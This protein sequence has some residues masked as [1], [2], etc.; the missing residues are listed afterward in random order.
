MAWFSHIST[1][2]CFDF[3]FGIKAE[4]VHC[5]LNRFELK[6]TILSNTCPTFPN[7]DH[8]TVNSPYRTINGLC[9]NIHPPGH[10]PWGLPKTQYQRAL[11]PNYA[12]GN[13]NITYYYFLAQTLKVDRYFINDF[14]II[15]WNRL[16]DA[17]TGQKW[18]RATAVR[19]WLYNFILLWP[20]KS[21]I[22]FESQTVPV[23]YLWLWFAILTPPAIRTLLG[24]CN[25]PNSSIM[26]NPNIVKSLD[27]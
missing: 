17:S 27:L 16:M 24:L 12:D 15:I 20:S 4:Q 9:N 2:G 13:D 3:R 19:I 1:I 14:V 5:A 6:D 18:W 11:A 23:W 26:V 21:I 7:C 10:V 22:P 25:S 8:N